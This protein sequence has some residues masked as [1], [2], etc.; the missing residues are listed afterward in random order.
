MINQE[1]RVGDIV[2][3]YFQTVGIF[4]AHQIDF[5]CGGKQSLLEA[6]EKKSIDTK[7]IITQLEEAIK[8]PVLGPKFDKMPL[9]EL[10]E[11]IKEKHHTYIRQQIP[12]LTKFLNKIEQVHGAHYPEIE[13]INAHFK[14]SV[15]NLSEH[16]EQEENEL[17]PLIEQLV[18]AENGSEIN[19]NEIEKK[20]SSLIN[21]HENEGSRFE[22]ISA[23]TLSYQPPQ[24]ACNTFR[25]SYENLH[26]FEKDLHRHVH[27]E[28]NILFPKAIELA[29]KLRTS[30]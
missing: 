7:E 19:S 28:N 30:N 16:M 8:I 12:L 17:F 25:A 29:L 9:G 18:N 23:L 22:E 24:G 1:T 20:I 21:D 6:C 4:D 27:L 15:K 13:I 26:A 2:K 14:E 11:Y 3:N 10:I 5:C